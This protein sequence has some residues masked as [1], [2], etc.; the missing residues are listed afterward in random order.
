MSN[1]ATLWEFITGPF[2]LLG[3]SFG[4][5]VFVLIMDMLYSYRVNMKNAIG[6]A[7]LTF[8]F[9]GLLTLLLQI[10][11]IAFTYNKLFDDQLMYMTES[12]QDRTVINIEEDKD[13]NSLTKYNITYMDD[14]NNSSEISVIFTEKQATIKDS[15]DGEYHVSYY[16][17]NDNEQV[18]FRIPVEAETGTLISN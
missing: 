3:I 13:I 5:A 2:I 4:F 1:F 7:S 17:N 8:C 6:M 14:N 16:K 18:I 10:V 15:N 11:F 9:M 12:L